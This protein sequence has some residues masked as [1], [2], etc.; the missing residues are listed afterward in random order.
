MATSSHP[1]DGP[2]GL[3]R[4]RSTPHSI[5]APQNQG[6]YPPSG[7]RDAVPLGQRDLEPLGHRNAGNGGRPEGDRPLVTEPV[8]PFGDQ[9]ANPAATHS[10]NPV[11]TAP[12]TVIN[13]AHTVVCNGPAEIHGPAHVHGG[14]DGGRR[15]FGMDAAGG[16]GGG[17][18][19]G[20]LAAWQAPIP[21][22]P[23]FTPALP[24]RKA[25]KGAV[26]AGSAMGFA[27]G[28]LAQFLVQ[29]GVDGAIGKVIPLIVLMLLLGSFLQALTLFCGGMRNFGEVYVHCLL[30]P[31]AGA[32]VCL[33]VPM[34]AEYPARI[35]AAI[36]LAILSA[37][38]LLAGGG[39]GWWAHGL[40]SLASRKGDGDEE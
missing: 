38:I 10:A 40:A 3:G 8:G 12:S 32:A 23:Y 22:M 35:S 29:Y 33:I 2:G 13:H 28:T 30:A 14:G 27:A 37:P 25:G 15:D 21:W 20:A 18:N 34:K 24:Q 39:I 19:V 31:L 6:D 17:G 4:F 1:G 9:N 7:H 5:A 36:S 26:I 11:A 16:G